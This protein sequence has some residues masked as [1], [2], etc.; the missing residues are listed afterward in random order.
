MNWNG[1]GSAPEKQLVMTKIDDTN[2]VRNEQAMYRQDHL[3]FAGDMYVYYSPTHW[4]PLTEIERLRIKN[5]E[6]RKA[7]EQLARAK[8]LLGLE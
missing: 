4:R 6:E 5:E 2:G 7:I 3:W 8:S 1:I